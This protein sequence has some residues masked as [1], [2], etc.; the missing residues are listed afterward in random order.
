MKCP[1]RPVRT[2]TFVANT[3]TETVQSDFGE[4]YESECPFYSPERKIT[5][6][7]STLEHCKRAKQ[8]VDK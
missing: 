3:N 4:C 5:E 6:N 2:T 7:L 8:E 1:W